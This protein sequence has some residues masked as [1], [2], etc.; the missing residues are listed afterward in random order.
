MSLKMYLI[1]SNDTINK[2]NNYSK[3]TTNTNLIFI[4]HVDINRSTV[5]S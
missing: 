3:T 5:G 1:S 4:L 2:L